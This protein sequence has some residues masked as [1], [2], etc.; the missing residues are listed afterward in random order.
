MSF[1]FDEVAPFIHAYRGFVS[2]PDNFLSVVDR[3]TRSDWSFISFITVNEGSNDYA[4]SEVASLNPLQSDVSDTLLDYLREHV[5][6]IEVDANESRDDY[7]MS[8]DIT[9]YEN[10]LYDLIRVS[11]FESSST[12]TVLGERLEEGLAI[13]VV[14]LSEES[15]IVF[16]DLELSVEMSVGDVL[17]APGGF[18][19]S[20][21][22]GEKSGQ[23]LFLKRLMR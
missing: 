13:E 22:V 17:Y 20:H 10:S 6:A 4:K 8:C 3:G 12:S 15:L 7:L 23:A 2:I 1:P 9:S 5:S 18:P 16:P 11:K 21:F 14:C 19:F